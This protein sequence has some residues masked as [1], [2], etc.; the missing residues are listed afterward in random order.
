MVLQFGSLAV[1]S[2]MCDSSCFNYPLSLYISEMLLWGRRVLLY[3]TVRW[4]VCTELYI[5]STSDVGVP[6]G[7]VS[8]FLTTPLDV[9][10]TR[11]MLAE[12]SKQAHCVPHTPVSHTTYIV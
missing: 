11:I 3:C 7:G 1:S 12:V 4:L 5:H 2:L 8:A 9:A 6:A 10:K